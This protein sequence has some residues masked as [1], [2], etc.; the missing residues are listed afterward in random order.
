M[1]CPCLDE[2]QGAC[3]NFE[4]IWNDVN[5]EPSIANAGRSAAFW[6]IS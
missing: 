2:R 3:L 6:T 5:A 4:L 1:D